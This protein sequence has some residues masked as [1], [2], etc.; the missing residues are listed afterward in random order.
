ML[1]TCARDT[2]TDPVSQQI[3]NIKLTAPPD[4]VLKV[5]FGWLVPAVEPRHYMH[6]KKELSANV[7]CNN[8]NTLTIEGARDMHGHVGKHPHAREDSRPEKSFDP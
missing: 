3:L 5:V 7:I 4:T 8:R 2:Y 1:P 6:A